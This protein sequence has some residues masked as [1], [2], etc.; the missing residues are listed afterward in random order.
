MTKSIDVIAMNSEGVN[1][2]PGLKRPSSEKIIE[3][4]AMQSLM[5]SCVDNAEDV[6]NTLHD[7]Y[8]S[9]H[10]P[11]NEKERV[12]M[13][14]ID[15]MALRKWFLDDIL[16]S[17]IYQEFS[18]YDSTA[19]FKLFSKPFH[20]FVTDRNIY[21]HGKICIESPDFEYIIEYIDADTKYKELAYVAPEMLKSYNEFYKEILR[22]I[23]EYNHVCQKR[24]SDSKSKS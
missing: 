5:K 13:M 20:Q 23:K 15:L 9:R 3:F 4:G 16:D 21:T 11:S 19:K 24:E 17:K 10:R 1:Y 8:L 22:V 12:E 6:K 18:K 14:K 2:I 7:M